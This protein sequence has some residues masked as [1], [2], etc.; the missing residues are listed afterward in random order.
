MKVENWCGYDIRFVEING[1]WWAILKDICDA[2][3]LQSKHVAE[4]LDPSM[5]E[6]VRVEA[7]N[8]VSNDLRSRGE[9]KTRW[10]LAIN[11]Q[12]I[13]EALFASRRLEARKFRLWAGTVMKKLR[14]T[15]GLE[16]YEVMRMTDP[17]IQAQIDDLLDTVFYDEETGKYM[18]SVTVRGGDVE[19]VPFE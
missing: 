2:L 15:V 6:R 13:Y 1:E 14:E 19:Q 12:G 4:R 5:L 18:R 9:N 3:K 8:T 17:T 16:G 10:M 7:S 11:E